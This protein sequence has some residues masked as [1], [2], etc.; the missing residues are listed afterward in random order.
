MCKPSS[1]NLTPMDNS[2]KYNSIGSAHP[3]MYTQETVLTVKEG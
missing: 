1:L 2:T 3:T